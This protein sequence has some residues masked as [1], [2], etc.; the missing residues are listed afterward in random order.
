MA[1]TTFGNVRISELQGRAD[2][3]DLMVYG[4]NPLL[5]D[6]A[7][8]EPS[9]FETI[10]QRFE[11]TRNHIPFPTYKGLVVGKIEEGQEIPFISL[12]TGTQTISAEDYGVRCGFTH[13]MIRDDQVDVMKYTTMEL[14][15]AHTRTKNRVAFAALESGAGNSKAAT[16][17]GTLAIKDIR[18]AKKAAAQFKEDGTNIPRPVH[19]THL[20]MNPDQQDDLIPDTLDKTPPGIV[21]DPNTG[22]IR[23][24]A[25]LSVIVTAWVT[26]GVALLVRAK[27]KLLYCVRE[28]LKLD[29]TENFANA[30]EEVRTLEAYTFAVLYGDNVYKITGC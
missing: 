28:E 12:G 17:S 5:L 23:G 20:I 22:D 8:E 10:F 15:K 9:Q 18:D 7:N 1:S 14:G 3:A 30:A 27:D 24:V 19:F 13:Q 6:G 11:L 21:L 25:G 29:R 4:L 26:P 2:F 16:I